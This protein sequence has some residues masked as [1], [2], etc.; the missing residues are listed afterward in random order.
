MSVHVVFVAPF[1]AETTLRYVAAVAALDDVHLS[2]VS[3]APAEQI[4]AA[5]RARL[6]AHWRVPDGL[7]AQAIADAVRALTQRHGQ[8]SRLLGILEHLQVPLGQVRDLLGIEGMGEHAAENFRDKSR[9]KRVLQAAGVPCARHA[10]V[11]SAEQAQ[12]FARAV[13]YPLVAKP[14]AGAGSM[15]LFRLEN[16]SML[17]EVLAHVRPSPERP[18]ML[19]E[20]LS[21]EE[22]SLDTVSIGGVHLWHSITRYYPSPLEVVENQWIQW[23]V[24]LPREVDAGEFD[25]ARQAGVQALDALGMDT[26]LSHMEWFRRPDGSVAVS[27]V[28]ARPPGAQIGTL[29]GY[30]HDIDTYHMWAR[31]VVHGIF[32]PPARRYAAGIAYLR[33]QGNGR[34][35]AITGLD[36]AQAEVGDLVI[37]ARL[38]QR[39]ATPASSYEGDGYVVMRHPDTEVVRH[40][41]ARTVELVRVELA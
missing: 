6:A 29:I 30:A 15:G 34:V 35:A 19:E 1:F 22:H 36:A 26:G 21:G 24:L 20:F 4:P 38:P 23:C 25:T 5:L 2:L 13:G 37:E 11:T 16:D 27:E 9:M 33:G 14:P 40:A 3:E 17:A 7:D 10:L 12:V 28:G 41:L 31:V 39:G 32:E 18:Y 8:P